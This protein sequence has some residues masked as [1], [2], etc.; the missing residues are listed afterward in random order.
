[1]EFSETFREALNTLS[2]NKLRS[3]LATLGI[4]IGIGSVITL[5]SL[6]Q[7]SQKAVQNQ[8]ESLGSNLLTILPG[9]LRAGDIRSASGTSTTLTLDDAMAIASDKSISDVK[10]V[11]AEILR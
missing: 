5:I 10:N 1:M 2:V 4:I 6:G 8:I 3:G 9:A 7:S 11:S